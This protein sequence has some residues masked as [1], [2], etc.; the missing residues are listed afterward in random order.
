MSE[1][2]KSTLESTCKYKCHAESYAKATG[3]ELAQQQIDQYIELRNIKADPLYYAE[4]GPGIWSLS[5]QQLLYLTLHPEQQ[6]AFETSYGHIDFGHALECYFK[7][8]G[9]QFP[10]PESISQEHIIPTDEQKV[11]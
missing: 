3:V 8:C 10:I 1:T 11:A 5:D 7:W 9:Y 2:L 4:N 6:A